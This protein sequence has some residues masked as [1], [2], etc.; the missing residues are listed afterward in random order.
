MGSR[1]VVVVCRDADAATRRFGVPDDS[2][3][4]VIVTRTGRRFFP[5]DAIES[6]LLDRMRGAVE[7]AGLWEDLDT[8]W[9]VLDAELLPWSA[10]AGDL[11]TRQYAPTG[12]AALGSLPVAAAALAR[13][14]DRGI[15]V[16]ELSSRT[17]ARV[18]MVAAYRQAYRQYCWPVASVDDLAVAPFQILAA[19]GEAYASDLTTGTWP[20]ST[21]WSTP[22][23]SCSGAP[24][25]WPSTSTTRHRWPRR[26]TG[27]SDSPRGGERDGGQ[28]HRDDRPGRPRRGPARHQV[29][30]P[31]VP[32]HHL[33]P[34]VHDRTEPRPAPLAWPRTQARLAAGEFA[35]GIEA[36]ERFVAGEPLYR[37]HQCVFGVLALESEPVDPTL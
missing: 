5:D 29:P 31:R 36:L 25:A 17:E 15:D 13:A 32:P 4:G 6:E 20:T 16:A 34:R 35:L 23:P 10:K 28:A 11:L 21:A 3:G 9:L 19:E 30:R 7:R 22:A 24:N 37:V 12:A 8:D 18:D 2:A 27:G 1:A 33:R 26:W 14:A